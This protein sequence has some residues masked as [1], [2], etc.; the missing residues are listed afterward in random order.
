MITLIQLE[1]KKCQI[2]K[3]I[4]GAIIS[5]IIILGI[6]VLITYPI[7]NF[8][9]DVISNYNIIFVMIDC[10][11][12][13]T[14][15]I[16]SSILTSKII[17]KGFKNKDVELLFS[18]PI[19]RKKLIIAKIFIIVTFAFLCIIL[20][21]IFLGISFYFLDKSLDLIPNKLDISIVANNSLRI[22]IYALT[23]S[24]MTLIPLYLG[25]IKKSTLV[26]I[27][28]SII[29]VLIVCSYNNGF[30]LNS[31]IEV[32]ISLAILGIVAAYL[33][34]KKIDD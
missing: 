27:L 8:K 31:I 33:S 14:F 17:I 9:E 6:L 26:T 22:F 32:P 30:S 24:I 11:V 34:I 12:R 15:I 28:T 29:L 23:S 16:F 4:K 20:S 19:D 2:K 25:L 1:L 10:L 18:Y 5:N 7:K 13:A 3:Y 21:N